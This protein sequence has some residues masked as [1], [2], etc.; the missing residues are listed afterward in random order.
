MIRKYSDLDFSNQNM[1][2]INPFDSYRMLDTSGLTFAYL[3]F[4]C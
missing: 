1:F 2:K 3:I 4:Y